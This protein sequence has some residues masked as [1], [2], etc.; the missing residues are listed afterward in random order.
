ME[1]KIVFNTGEAVRCRSIRRGRGGPSFEFIGLDGTVMP[2]D[3]PN[4]E[5]V[6]EISP[7]AAAPRLLMMGDFEVKAAEEGWS[8]NEGSGGFLEIRAADTYAP[9]GEPLCRFSTDELAGVYVMEQADEGSV[10]HLEMLSRI[11]A[12]NRRR[13]AEM[14]EEETRRDPLGGDS[15]IFM[16]L[17]TW[18]SESVVDKSV[19]KV[20]PGY[21][22]SE[23]PQQDAVP[24]AVG[25]NQDIV[26]LRESDAVPDVTTRL[27]GIKFAPMHIKVDRAGGIYGCRCGGC[28]GEFD[29]DPGSS[30]NHKVVLVGGRR[31]DVLRCPHCTAICREPIDRG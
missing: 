19:C 7:V 6:V 25:S 3:Y 27:D 18:R 29:I 5:D 21:C 20:R 28:G 30:Y 24:F 23:G 17:R 13:W 11:T 9:G 10:Y 26:D 8:V 22:P 31:V 15:W 1:L 12:E 4:L 2:G 16:R 14:S